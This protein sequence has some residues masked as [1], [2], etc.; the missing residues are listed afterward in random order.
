MSQ[1]LTGSCKQTA[2]GRALEDALL[3]RVAEQPCWDRRMCQVDIGEVSLM[4]YK[5]TE[6]LE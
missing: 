1:T 2:Q 4:N 6:G 5:E 3:S